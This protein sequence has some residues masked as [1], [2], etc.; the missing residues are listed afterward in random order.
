MGDKH[1]EAI[2]C[3]ET[4]I[5]DLTRDGR[6]HENHDTRIERCRS[7]LA[8]HQ[9]K[10]DDA[11]KNKRDDELKAD[12]LRASIAVLQADQGSKEYA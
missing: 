4:W 7:N 8:E 10:L 5:D 1:N 3:I 11:I 12:G 9:R 6:S 2:R